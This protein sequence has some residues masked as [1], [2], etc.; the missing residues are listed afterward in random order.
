MAIAVVFV[1]LCWASFSGRTV[2]LSIGLAIIGVGSFLVV[3]LRM[4]PLG[5]MGTGNIQGNLVA[6]YGGDIYVHS[7]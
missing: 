1:F 4:Q 5:K 3:L 6:E 7:S 2:G